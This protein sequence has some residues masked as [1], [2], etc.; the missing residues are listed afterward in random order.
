MKEKEPGNKK[1]I[2]EKYPWVNRINLQICIIPRRKSQEF[3]KKMG[4][5][6]F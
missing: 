3:E 2:K 1:D 5:T 4:K 6:G